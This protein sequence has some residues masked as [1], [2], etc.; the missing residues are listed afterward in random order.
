MIDLFYGDESQ[1]ST[2]GYVPYG[3]QFAGE[4]VFVASE[5]G[6]KINCFALLSRQ[7]QC[8]WRTTTQNIDAAF[9]LEQLENLAFSIRKHTVVVLDNAPAHTAKII[10]ER[11]PFWQQKGLFIFFLPPYS[12]HLNIAETLWRHLKKLWLA[13]EDYLEK[14]NL[15]FAVNRA[16]AALGNE[17]NILFQPFNSN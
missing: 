11:I 10:R 12:P 6:A 9:V 5:R 7:N 13:P 15:F 2:E 14:Q 3:W 1:V 8:H 4:E 17:L 16:L